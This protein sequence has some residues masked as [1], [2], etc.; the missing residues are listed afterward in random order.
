MPYYAIL[1]IDPDRS[2]VAYLTSLPVREGLSK[3]SGYYAISLLFTIFGIIVA[4]S[5][6]GRLPSSSAASEAKTSTPATVLLLFGFC[7][8]LVIVKLSAAGGLFYIIGNIASRAELLAGTGVYDIFLTPAIFLTI[9][10]ATRVHS[11]RRMRLILLI[12]IVSSLFVLLAVFGGR[13]IPIF[14]LLFAWIAYQK[15][16]R[17]IPLISLTSVG[18]TALIVIFFSAMLEWRVNNQ[19]GSAGD[20]K[21]GA[22]ST[23]ANL[24]YLDTY[25]FITDYFDNHPKWQGS[26]FKDLIARFMIPGPYGN[27]PLD[28]GVYIRTLAEGYHV[29]PSLPFSLM[30]PSS[31]PPESYGNGYANFGLIGA[32]LFSAI[33][34][35]VIG[36]GFAIARSHGFGPKSFFLALTTAFNFHFTNLRLTQLAMVLCGFVVIILIERLGARIARMRIR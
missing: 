10:H 11:Q 17:K 29:V 6:R 8:A 20:F 33:R 31:W 18:L 3:V 14:I 13:K 16:V 19:T 24:S 25:L 7:V 1:A 28:E 27:P 9:L 26:S 12:F 22:V 5:F 2:R 35:I 30:Y 23:I 4:A 21:A 15:Y 36:T 34:G 32:L